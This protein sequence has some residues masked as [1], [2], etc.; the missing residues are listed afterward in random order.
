MDVRVKNDAKLRVYGDRHQIIGS[1]EDEG[2]GGNFYES[3]Y[4]DKHLEVKKDLIRHIEG[5][6]QL[7]IGLG[8]ADDGGNLD[9]V[10]E[11]Q[12]S[13]KIGAD[14]N[15]SVGGNTS[16]DVGNNFSRKI[17]GDYQQKVGGSHAVDA[18]Q[19]IHIK[20][21]MTVVVEAAAQLTLKV[22]GNFIDISA[23]GIAIKGSIVLI[24][25][26]GAPGSGTGASPKSP[27]A[28]KEAESKEPKV[29]A[30]ENKH[31]SGQLSTPF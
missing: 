30:K 24:N 13:R 10:V 31:K 29:A 23:A 16:E 26:G 9:V 28:A 2:E 20:S 6:S 19:A 11:K 14:L 8:D 21:G 4:Q 22:G 27:A 5:N 12:E 3:I 18:G 1:D 17:G 15:I 25:S 7:M